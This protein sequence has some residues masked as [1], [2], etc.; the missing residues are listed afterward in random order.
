VIGSVLTNT[1]GQCP[2]WSCW[3]RSSMVHVCFV[4]LGKPNC[5]MAS[6]ALRAS[7]PNTVQSHR[8]RKVASV[9]RVQAGQDHAQT[10]RD[11]GVGES[12]AYTMRIDGITMGVVETLG[13]VPHDLTGRVGHHGAVCAA[14]WMSPTVPSTPTPG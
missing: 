14:T 8:V 12:P 10:R 13:D 7:V 3:R 4:V 5:R 6:T 1:I 9:P 2:P 11:A